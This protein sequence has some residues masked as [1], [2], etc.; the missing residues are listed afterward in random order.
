M[1]WVIFLNVP[2]RGKNYVF[3]NQEGGIRVMLTLVKTNIFYMMV[4]WI[5]SKQRSEAKNTMVPGKI[6]TDL[7]WTLPFVLRYR[8]MQHSL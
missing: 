6:K 8:M 5:F 2:R 1:E 4:C 7:R 3:Q